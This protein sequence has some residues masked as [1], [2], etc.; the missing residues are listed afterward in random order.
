MSTAEPWAWTSIAKSYLHAKTPQDVQA[1]AGPQALHM[2]ANDYVQFSTTGA[3]FKNAEANPWVAC[4]R[5]RSN[6]VFALL[7]LYCFQLVQ[8]V[9]SKYSDGLNLNPIP[10]INGTRPA[11]YWD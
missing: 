6:S 8:H 9:P 10:K 1:H 5:N 3:L 7:R 11:F 2:A 4:R